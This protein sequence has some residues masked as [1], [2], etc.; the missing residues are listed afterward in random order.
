MRRLG[1]D[2]LGN[3]F[4]NLGHRVKVGDHLEVGGKK[5]TTWVEK[6]M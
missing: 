5:L 4:H 6:A 2:P 1:Q 3:C